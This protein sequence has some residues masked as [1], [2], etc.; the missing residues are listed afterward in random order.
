MKLKNKGKKVFGTISAVSILL[1]VIVAVL[2]NVLVTKVDWSYDVTEK[3][4]YT[5]SKQ[6]QKIVKNLQKEVTIYFLS[7][8]KNTD[9]GY[10]KIVNEYV[11]HS[12]HVTVKYRDM[13]LYPK[14]AG[15]YLSSGESAEEGGILV[16]CGDKGKYLSPNDFVGTGMDASGNYNTE[17]NLES[18]LTTA[19]NYVTSDQTPRIYLL[20][21][22]GETDLD[23]SF[24]SSIEADNYEF[25]ELNLLTRANVPKD[26]EILMVNAPTADIT[27][28]DL[29]KVKQYLKNG[30]RL[31]YVCNTDADT[32]KN[33]ESLLQTYGVGVNDGIVVET[34]SSMYM[35]YPTYILPTIEESEITSVLAQNNSNILVPVSKGLTVTKD[36]AGLLSTSEDAYSKV[37]VESGTVE[38]EKGDLDG[39]FSLAAQVEDKNGDVKVVVLGSP[40]MMVAEI[41]QYVSGANSDFVSNCVNSLA[42]QQEKISIK[43]KTIS[44]DTGTYTTAAR[45]AIPF[46]AVIGIPACILLIG[47]IIVLLRKKSK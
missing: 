5:I 4:I 23:A 28:A 25:K 33:F 34:K 38:K 13:E 29:K 16:V 21:G 42:K 7:S 10:Q 30:G 35:Q 46:L 15:K 2:L 14:F 36:A 3:K 9:G 45:Q 24:Q 26:C 22:H 47:G 11:K 20:N 31:F 17:V 27:A 6:S 19:I 37:D 43:A 1:I 12:Q 39:P 40:S 41:D 32:L 44:N 8:K 18:L